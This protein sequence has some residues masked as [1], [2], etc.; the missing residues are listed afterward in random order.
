MLVFAMAAVLGIDKFP[1][2]LF[3]EPKGDN[4]LTI[5]TSVGGKE[6]TRQVKYFMSFSNSKS[7]YRGKKS[8]LVVARTQKQFDC[9]LKNLIGRKIKV[10][11]K[12][13]FDEEM[14]IFVF[15]GTD[16]VNHKTTVEI[17]SLERGFGPMKEDD[18]VFD[19]FIVRVQTTCLHPD[20]DESDRF[21]PWTMI[22]INK[23][24]YEH[25]ITDYTSFVMIESRSLIYMKNEEKLEDDED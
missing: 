2:W 17:E 1:E 6:L 5:V 8:K 23:K 16:R 20:L 12:L 21:S 13:N 9:V 22:R 7:L 10:S 4:A 18:F 15:A 19:P 3:E 24:K 14:F 25:P 11:R